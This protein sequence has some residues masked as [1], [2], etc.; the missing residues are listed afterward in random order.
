[1]LQKTDSDDDL[2]VFNVERNDD[3]KTWLNTNYDKPGNRWNLDNQWVFVLRNS[4]HF[5]LNRFRSGE[6]CF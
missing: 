3:G 2:N 1:M 6:F 4:L 5:S